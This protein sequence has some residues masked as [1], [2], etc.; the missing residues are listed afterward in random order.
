MQLGR[1]AWW[2]NGDD[3]ERLLGT[4]LDEVL[5][6]SEEWTEEEAANHPGYDGFVTDDPVML[7]LHER[8]SPPFTEVEL[9]RMRAVDRKIFNVKHDDCTKWCA[10]CSGLAG[11]VVA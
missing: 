2:A 3:D 9:R 8:D 6:G 10:I 7:A 4:Q 5:E 1:P 11:K